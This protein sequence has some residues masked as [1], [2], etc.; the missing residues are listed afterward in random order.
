MKMVAL[1]TYTDPSAFSEFMG[2]FGLVANVMSLL[3]SVLGT[4][5]AMKRLPLQTCLLVFP[6]CL[7]LLIGIGAV[8]RDVLAFASG[9]AA[10]TPLQYT[11]TRIC[12]F[13]LAVW[14]ASRRLDLP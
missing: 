10:L 1:H 6:T 13:C 9:R 7:A 5:H 12:G 2:M 14:C 3:L 4:R 11:S 8:L